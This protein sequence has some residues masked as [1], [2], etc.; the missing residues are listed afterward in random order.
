MNIK[1]VSTEIV[2]IGTNFIFVQFE[3][4]KRKII[5]FD[6]IYLPNFW[7]QPALLLK[8]YLY[9]NRKMAEKPLAEREDKSN[10]GRAV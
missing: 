6:G 9:L 7:W 2:E 5:F 8:K 10:Y 3:V 1:C 4:Y